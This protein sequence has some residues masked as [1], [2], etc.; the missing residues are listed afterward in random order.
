MNQQQK[1]ELEEVLKL[2]NNKK[3]FEDSFEQ[4]DGEE[5]SFITIGDYHFNNSI[6]DNK[7]ENLRYVEH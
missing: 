5:L 2:R 4:E 6:N 1:S 7:I 3:F